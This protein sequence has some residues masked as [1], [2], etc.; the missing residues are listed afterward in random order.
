MYRYL[1]TLKN[2]FFQDFKK[3]YYSQFG[4]DVFIFNTIEPGFFV[5]IGA[6][7]PIK[8]SNT[9]K[10]YKS[11]WRG[12]NI[13]PRPGSKKLFDLLRPNDIN[14]ECAITEKTGA[15][16]YYFNTKTPAISTL[17]PTYFTDPITIKTTT[18]NELLAKYLP[19]N[20]SIQLLNIDTEGYDETILKSL[21]FSLYAPKCICIEE[22][23]PH[24][25][26]IN[27]STIYK[28]LIKKG[29]SLVFFSSHSF[30]YLK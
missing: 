11:G 26:V 16:P 13:E 15:A 25:E 9:Y 23:K 8:Y 3:S 6:F 22:F 24:A 12:I 4:E 28:L 30:I 10:L 7:H 20:Q 29:Y 27:S 1:K 17:K 21:D 5:D 2:Y 18:I 19:D 14:F